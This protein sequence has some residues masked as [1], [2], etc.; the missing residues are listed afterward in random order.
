MVDI[1]LNLQ[2]ELSKCKSISDLTGENGLFKKLMKQM[3]EGMLEEEI[4]DYL[5]YPK[6]SPS[7]AL[8]GN[9][10][11][12]K[13]KKTVKSSAGKLEL[14]VPRDRLSKFEPQVVR[15][16]Q[17][18]ITEFDNKIISMYGKGM[19][20]RDIQDHVDEIYGV[21]SISF[22]HLKYHTESTADR[23]RMAESRT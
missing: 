11:N 12:G 4:E 21:E 5:G 18:D 23:D 9:S 1:N 7:E 22:R 17:V 8:K 16:R 15:K 3:I 10:R 20:T 19:S 6:N 13:N 2:E 14:D